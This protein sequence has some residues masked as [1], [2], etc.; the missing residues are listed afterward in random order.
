MGTRRVRSA[1]ELHLPVLQLLAL[2][3]P[4]QAQA[5]QTQVRAAMHVHAGP[6]LPAD[7][8][9]A[10]LCLPLACTDSYPVQVFLLVVGYE[11]W[12][13][14]Q[15]PKAITREHAF[16]HDSGWGGDA[17]SLAQIPYTCPPAPLSP[18]MRRYALGLSACQYTCF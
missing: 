4:L 2:Q 18:C 17:H 6:L 7:S 10:A 14:P 12:S 9:A 5:V 16:H 3:A 1:I 8:E 15:R 11:A 13:S